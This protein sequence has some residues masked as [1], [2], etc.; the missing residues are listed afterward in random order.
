VNPKD[1][2]GLHW[3]WYK[4]TDCYVKLATQRQ[5]THSRSRT[6]VGHWEHVCKGNLVSRHIE[7]PILSF[8]VVFEKLINYSRLKNIDVYIIQTHF[9][10]ILP[11]DL[12]TASKYIPLLKLYILTYILLSLFLYGYISKCVPHFKQ[13]SVSLFCALCSDHFILRLNGSTDTGGTLD[14]KLLTFQ[15]LAV[16]SHTIRFNIKKFYVVPTLRLCVLYGSQNKQQLLPYNTLRG[17]F[18]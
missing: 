16:T 3:V 12:S 1:Y 11:L 5:N 6:T 9:H 17:W 2:T 13:F 4:I 10:K 8:K 14:C 18:L 7:L 15:S